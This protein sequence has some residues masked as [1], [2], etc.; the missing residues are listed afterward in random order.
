MNLKR[1]LISAL[2]IAFL[3]LP[4]LRSVGAGNESGVS[5]MRP[6]SNWWGSHPRWTRWLAGTLGGVVGSAFG[7]TVFSLLSYPVFSSQEGISPPGPSSLYFG[8]A[9]GY[10]LGSGLGAG[11]GVEKS[12]ELLG[13][14]RKDLETYLTSSLTAAGTFY[15]SLA[16]N[17]GL[18]NLTDDPSTKETI[19]LATGSL[20]L[21]TPLVS[22]TVA[23]WRYGSSSSQNNSG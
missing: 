19:N 20:T 6:S 4:A 8:F 2:V 3:L 1:V 11:F 5:E 13:R 18:K 22:S 16:L 21:A 23:S 12:A 7:T 9:V 17:A 15:G 14:D 10:P